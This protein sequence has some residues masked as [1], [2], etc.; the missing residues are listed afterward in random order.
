M[1]FNPAFKKTLKT[2]LKCYP[3]NFGPQHLVAYSIL[4]IILSLYGKASKVSGNITSK[5]NYRLLLSAAVTSEV[6]DNVPFYK[7][8]ELYVSIAI[9]LGVGF[10]LAGGVSILCTHNLLPSVT[11]P[12]LSLLGLSNKNVVQN[13]DPIK[14]QALDGLA[15]TIYREK[16]H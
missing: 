9:G 2:F 10:A 3:L 6:S 12:L 5:T 11:V 4:R 7:Q 8:P 1:A 14:Q 15:N 13:V 16:P